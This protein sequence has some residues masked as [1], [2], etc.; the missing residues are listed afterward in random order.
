SFTMNDVFDTDDGPNALQNYPFVRSVELIG[1]GMKTITFQL[2]AF[3][4]TA[5]TIDFY[6]VTEPDPS[7]FGE[8]KT[9]I[10][11]DTATPGNDGVALATITVPVAQLVS[12]TATSP[13][14]N[15]S[16]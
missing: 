16:E 3:T 8:G 7:G 15:T 1:G 12:A 2:S 13:D 6:S 14:G 10:S 11:T 5:Y 4:N 9:F